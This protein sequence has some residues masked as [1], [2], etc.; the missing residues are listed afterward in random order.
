MDAELNLDEETIQTKYEGKLKKRYEEPTFRIVT[1]IFKVLSG[2][3]LTA[4]GSFTSTSDQSSVKCN[5]KATEGL[6]YPLDKSILWV[7]K[8]PI[9]ISHTD[10]HQVIFSRVGL[11]GA[12]AGVTSSKTFDLRV[13][14]RATGQEHTFAAIQRDEYDKLN[15]HF[16]DKRLRIKNEMNEEGVLGTAAA[17]AA[18]DQD[19][20]DEDM[21]DGSDADGREGQRKSKKKASKASK[22]AAAMAEDEDS[23]EDDE[24]FEAPS[25]DDGGS[26][27]EA[28]S[29]EGGGS[30][31]GNFSDAS[32][33]SDAPKKK[34]AKK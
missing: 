18:L 24:D 15:A 22:A 30:D 13:L 33:D 19:D 4:P 9:W 16:A 25:E 14:T 10:I 31:D 28:S 12:T 34:K 1:N 17:V 8:Q 27:S 11:G 21:D 20:S 7:S 2:Q 5:V 32:E 26:P 29:D 6:L 23:D 3:K